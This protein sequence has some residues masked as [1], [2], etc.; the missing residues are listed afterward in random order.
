MALAMSF[1]KDVK[2]IGEPARKKLKTSDLPV[3]S[4]LRDA[5]QQLALTFK[6]KGDY[7]ALRKQVWEKLE[8]SVSSHFGKQITFNS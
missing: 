7:D 8:G 2:G 1:S 6:K 5:S 3:A 4:A